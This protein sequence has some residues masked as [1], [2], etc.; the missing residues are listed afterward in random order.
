MP[1][2]VSCRPVLSRDGH[3]ASYLAHHISL[4]LVLL[5]AEPQGVTNLLPIPA[6]YTL[7]P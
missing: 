2:S 6:L 4:C 3:E 7:A 5:Q 1:T